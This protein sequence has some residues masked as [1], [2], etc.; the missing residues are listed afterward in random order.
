ME[1]G[2]EKFYSF[3]NNENPHKLEH[4]TFYGAVDRCS[5]MLVFIY[6]YISD[7]EYFFRNVERKGN[8]LEFLR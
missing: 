2:E 7:S 4:P 5:S 3:P 8:I 1:K 6:V